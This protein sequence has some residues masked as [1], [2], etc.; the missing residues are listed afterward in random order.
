MPTVLIP[1]HSQPHLRLTDQRCAACDC[2]AGKTFL[3]PECSELGANRRGALPDAV[4]R[5]LDGEASFAVQNKREID[6]DMAAAGGSSVR[7]VCVSAHPACMSVA[8][9]VHM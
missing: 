4:E 7:S 3:P 2:A 6:L 5:T 1:K 8:M 9:A